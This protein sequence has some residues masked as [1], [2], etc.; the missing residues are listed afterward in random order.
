MYF[1][2]SS[3]LELQVEVT[4][5]VRDGNFSLRAKV[6]RIL[7]LLHPNPLNRNIKCRV[8]PQHLIRDD[9]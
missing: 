2:Q 7:L 5:L 9:L 6:L 3:S 4:P 8:G 1:Y